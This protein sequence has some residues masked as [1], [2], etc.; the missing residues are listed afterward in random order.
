MSRAVQLRVAPPHCPSDSPGL[1]RCVGLMRSMWDLQH[2][3][4]GTGTPLGPK[5]VDLNLTKVRAWVRELA[6]DDLDVQDT[7]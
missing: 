7:T 3:L 5:K 6:G 1:L 2:S 4:S